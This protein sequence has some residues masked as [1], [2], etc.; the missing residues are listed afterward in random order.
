MI[1]KSEDQEQIALMQ[2]A[3]L[4]PICKEYLIHIPNGGSRHPL[5]ALKLKKMGVKRGVSD[6]FLAYPSRGFHGLWI[7]MKSK[8]GSITSYQKKW[9]HSM[10]GIGYNIFVAY[11][12]EEAKETIQLYLDEAVK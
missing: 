4:H 9:L 2:W 1:K 12:F 3:A 6:L 7:E 11:S 5:E 10:E 8:N